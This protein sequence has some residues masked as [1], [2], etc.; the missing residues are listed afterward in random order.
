MEI[1]KLK[2]FSVIG[3]EG[4]TNDGAGFITNLVKEANQDY[5]EIKDLV[6]TNNNF[7]AW[8]LMSDFNRRLLPWEDNF[9]KGLYLFG[10][11]VKED[12]VAPKGWVKWSVPEREYIK[13]EVEDKTKYI[14]TFQK[15]V[16]FML[17]YLKYDLIGAAFD[18][19]DFKNNKMYIFFPVKKRIEVIKN[20]PFDKMLS[21]CGIHCGYC[22]F[23]SCGGC[24]TNPNNCSFGFQFEDK[25]CPNAK[26]CIEKGIKGCYECDELEKCNKGFYSTKQ[27]AKVCSLF[28]KKEGE[29]AFLKCVENMVKNG[30][31][32][33]YDLDNLPTDKDK[34]DFLYKYS[35]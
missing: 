9:S 11:Q 8:G 10:V 16:Y 23:P 6:D 14:E 30:I 13:V 29:E 3:K 18:F 17:D 7:G 34:M 22:F 21:Y 5:L 19:N 24:R 15:Y 20:I 26:C 4:S 33:C 2:A 31:N 12:A 35:K 32:Y 25:K 28:I 27:S 1:I